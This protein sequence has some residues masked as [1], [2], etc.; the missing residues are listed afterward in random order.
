[1][2]ERLIIV[3]AGAQAR[4]ILNTV[5]LAN[6]LE[7]V[8]LIDTFNNPAIWG[9]EVDGVRVLGTLEI[10][11]HYPPT[12]DLKVICAIADVG[13]KRRTVENLKSCGYSFGNA[14]H[15][16][17]LIADRVALGEGII[18]NAGVVIETGS[19]IGDHVIIHAGCVVEHDNVLE[20]FVNLGPGVVTAGR[21]H[22]KSGSIV[23]TGASI[24]PNVVVGEDT[25]IGAGAVV[26]RDVAP[27]AKVVGVPAGPIETSGDSE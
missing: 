18:I 10:L 14:I 8:G 21:V 15:P 7:V 4:Y 9:K 22:V 1:M 6:G 27:G 24:I 25:V 23:Y 16:S 12:S 11:R 3:G 13:V 2:P 20:D 5:G 19:I 17:A 26:I